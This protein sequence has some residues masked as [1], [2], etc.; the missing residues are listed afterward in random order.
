MGS[1]IDKQKRVCDGMFWGVGGLVEVIKKSKKSEIDVGG[2]LFWSLG[3]CLGDC[4]EG[5]MPFE[6]SEI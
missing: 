1:Y 3:P 5:C 4:V 6:V 2:A